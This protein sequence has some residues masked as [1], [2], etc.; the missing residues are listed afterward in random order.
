M[1]VRYGVAYVNLFFIL[2]LLTYRSV[3]YHIISYHITSLH[4]MY[5]VKN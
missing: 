5:G 1:G 3:F 2:H 4:I